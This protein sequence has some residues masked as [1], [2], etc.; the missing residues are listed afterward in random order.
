[1]MVLI[2]WYYDGCIAQME[3]MMVIVIIALQVM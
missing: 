1:M 2:E 3:L